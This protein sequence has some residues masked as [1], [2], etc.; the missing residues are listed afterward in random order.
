MKR[1]LE[2]KQRMLQS[3]LTRKSSRY[4]SFLIRM[5]QNLINKTKK[6]Q[7]V[8]GLRIYVNFTRT[9]RCKIWINTWIISSHMLAKI[10]SFIKWIGGAICF[11]GW[12][13]FCHTFVW[14]SWWVFEEFWCFRN[15]ADGIGILQK[16]RYDWQ[17]YSDR[18]S[19][20]FQPFFLI[21]RP[22][23]CYLYISSESSQNSF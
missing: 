23:I 5:M 19:R 8:D 7:Y 18:K 17:S 15:F 16:F 1:L 12:N 13:T 4:R 11:F 3:P 6:W 2:W 10:K 21:L 22:G 9:D 14:Y 20:C